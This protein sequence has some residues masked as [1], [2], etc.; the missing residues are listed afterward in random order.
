M[1]GISAL[2]FAVLCG[3]L[4]IITFWPDV[5]AQNIDRLR[6]VIG[7]APVAQLESAFLSVKD[8]VQ[9][10]EYQVGLLHPA[11]PW[12]VPSP[13]PTKAPAL[14][15][16]ATVTPTT[17]PA[18][19]LSDGITPSP[20]QPTRRLSNGITPS[21][22]QPT[23]TPLTGVKPSP[24]RANRVVSASLDSI[25]P[26]PT[27]LPTLLPPPTAS[28]TPVI[29]SMLP[30]WQPAPLTPLGRLAGEGQWSPYLL[31]ADG[32]TPVAYRT[33]LQPDPRRPYSIPAI[34]AFDLQATRLHFVLGSVE[35]RSTTPRP[36]GTGVIPAADLRPGVLLATFNGGFKA[37]HGEYGAMAGGFVA[38]PP[39]NGLG[40]VA[41][42]SDGR[43][44]IGEWGKDIKATPDMVAWRQNGKMLVHN[45]KINP[46]TALTTAGWGV[47][48][49][50]E[51]V[52][53]RSGL[54]LSADGRT[55]YYVAGLQ[56]D[57]ATLARVMAQA[58]AAEAFE[59]DV[60]EFWV[61]FAAIRSNGSNLVAEPLLSAMK[62]QVDRYLKGFSRDFF[63]VTTTT[64]P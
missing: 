62:S 10:F 32:Q 35:P 64:R 54:G 22:I 11:A 15:S 39:I 48:I 9:Q 25:T 51:A 37:R 47:T 19:R 52:T 20:T 61:H 31:A 3:G 30:A 26:F 49:K 53:W 44:K 14:A 63:Y 38:L 17:L 57:V 28:P 60:N 56:L 7:D 34:V 21:P 50:G 24:G 27:S 4:A 40:T 5:A 42:Y 23:S 18:R 13:V 12:Q 16:V 45:G 59:L 2:V 33:F 6:D 1:L 8:S 55:L 43:V 41:M 29:T 46:A 36:P 58:G